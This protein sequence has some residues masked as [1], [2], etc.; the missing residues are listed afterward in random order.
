M[1]NTPAKRPYPN[2]MNS[3]AEFTPDHFLALVERERR[4]CE[5]LLTAIATRRELR[6]LNIKLADDDTVAV[7]LK[8]RARWLRN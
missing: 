2:N 3:P 6:D 7:A 5:L 8:K 4:W 1:R